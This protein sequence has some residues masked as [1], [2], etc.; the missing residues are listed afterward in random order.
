MEAGGA[1]PHAESGRVTSGLDA[2]PSGSN[3]QLASALP[4]G[5]HVAPHVA[6]RAPIADQCDVG[7]SGDAGADVQRRLCADWTG[8][9]PQE[10]GQLLVAGGVRV[11]VLFGASG[12][13]PAEAARA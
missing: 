7:L 2:A 6:A 8:M 1:V 11:S 13:A 9:T 4:V 5:V 10:V 12:Q 3:T